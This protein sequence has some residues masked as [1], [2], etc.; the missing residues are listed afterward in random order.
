[1]ENVRRSCPT[2]TGY[3]KSYRKGEFRLK[4]IKCNFT[5][6]IVKYFGYVI[7]E[8]SVKLLN[9]YLAAIKEF[10]LPKTKNNIR[11]VLVKINFYHKYN[12]QAAKNL[13][14]FYRL[15]KK[16]AY[17]V[18]YDERQQLFEKMKK[19]VASSLALAIFNPELP[20]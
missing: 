5:N 12:S 9:D 20:I 3:D 10:S 17:F 6:N 7:E 2:F 4:F 19:Y 11:Q 13:E 16:N 14:P 18:W 15:L 1:M 8:N